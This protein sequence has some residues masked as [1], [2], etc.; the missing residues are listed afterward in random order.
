MA[1]E[2]TTVVDYLNSIYKADPAAVH[3][4]VCNRVPCNRNITEHPHA[5]V[6]S[7]KVL[8]GDTDAIGILGVINGLLTSN[9]LPRVATEWS[10]DNKFV[11]FRIADK[12]S[13]PAGV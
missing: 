7:I 5:V 2:I 13:Q 6:E 9:G 8:P 10:N 11:G 12:A 4:L 1:L 3:A